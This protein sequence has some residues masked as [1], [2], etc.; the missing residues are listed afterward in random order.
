[1]N[2]PRNCVSHES[3]MGWGKP[4]TLKQGFRHP[5]RNECM[6]WFAQIKLNEVAAVKGANYMISGVDRL[7]INMTWS[8]LS[9]PNLE[10]DSVLAIMVRTRKRE[11]TPK[12]DSWPILI[13]TKLCST[14][15]QLLQWLILLCSQR[16]TCQTNI[17]SK[18]QCS[19]CDM[20]MN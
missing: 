4:T 19:Q 17:D 9:A 8:H 5:T 15:W 7:A 2:L 6:G 11:S 10:I 20:K 1:M 18:S 12:N 16:V 13:E 3:S 14:T